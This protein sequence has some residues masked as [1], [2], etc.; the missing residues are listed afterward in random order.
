MAKA[1]HAGRAAQAGLLA[2]ELSRRGFTQPPRSS[3]AVAASAPSC[4]PTATSRAPP[5]A[6]ARAGRSLRTASS[7][8]SCGVVCHPAID[9]ALV[10][11]AT[12]G[13]DANAV[14]SIEARV[15]PSSGRRGCA[16]TRLRR[17]CSC[18]RGTGHVRAASVRSPPRAASMAAHDPAGPAPTTTTSK[19]F[20]GM[21]WSDLFEERVEHGVGVADHGEVGE[22]HHRT[23]RVGVDADDVFR[24]TEPTGV[25]HRTA[26][27]EGD[28]QTGD[29]R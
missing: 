8:L 23:E 5:M 18:C 10:F 14:E 15:H 7:P 28:V 3:K 29:R 26:D 24:L 19:S 16:G 9:A 17:T 27:A 21:R 25:L 1:M 12:P 22:L 2:A 6:S 11:R 13:F 20:S 4:R